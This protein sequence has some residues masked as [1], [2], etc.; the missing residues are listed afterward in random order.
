M[1]QYLHESHQ[2]WNQYVR[3]QDAHTGGNKC[4]E[5][6]KQMPAAP[7][8]IETPL[9]MSPRNCKGNSSFG[10]F[11]SFLFKRKVYGS[12]FG[13]KLEELETLRELVTKLKGSENKTLCLGI[14]KMGI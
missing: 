12:S 11:K 3:F 10:N 8:T 6:R 9:Q 14:K 7:L 13:S 5:G 4:G 1:L 2:S